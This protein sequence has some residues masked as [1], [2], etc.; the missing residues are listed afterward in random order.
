M[1]FK[2][3]ILEIRKTNLAQLAV[4]GAAGTGRGIP[5]PWWWC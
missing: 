1:N 2:Q 5:C 4:S 3:G